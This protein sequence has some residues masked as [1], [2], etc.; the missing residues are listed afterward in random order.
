MPSALAPLL[1]LQTSQAPEQALLQHTPSLQKPLSQSA[2][3]LQVAP[4]TWNAYT[5]P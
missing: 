3:T 4:K 1:F 5:A 2:F